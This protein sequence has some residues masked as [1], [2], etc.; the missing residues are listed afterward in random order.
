MKVA[1]WISLT[2]SVCHIQCLVV[3]DKF[4]FK[5]GELAADFGSCWCPLI[6][7]IGKTYYH[8]I[9][10]KL[11]TSSEKKSFISCTSPYMFNRGTAREP[12]KIASLESF[13]GAKKR[14]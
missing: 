4:I 7:A 6:T 12:H 11:N 9:M 8:R 5:L 13:F 10:A 1:L 14:S 2:S 3:S